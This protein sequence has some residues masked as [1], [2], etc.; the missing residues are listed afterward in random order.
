VSLYPCSSCGKRPQGKLSSVTWAWNRADATRTAWRQRLC[1]SCFTLNVQ[2]L[3]QL[4][5]DQE[6]VC[7]RCGIGTASDMDPVFATAFV[8]T[9]GRFD[10]EWATCASCAV[11]VRRLAQEGAEQLDDRR[12]DRLGAGGSGPQTY[13]AAETWA[14]LGGAGG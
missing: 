7:P 4:S 5:P 6:I 11:E 12:Q 13:S 9:V 1:L 2:G 14:A 3:P 8:P 10:F